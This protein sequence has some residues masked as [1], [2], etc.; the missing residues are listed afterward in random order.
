[1]GK[2]VRVYISIDIE[3]IAGVTSRRHS[4]MDG[5]DYGRARQWMTDTAVAAAEAA[6]SAGASEVVV[7]D[8]HGKK[9]NVHIDQLPAGCRLVRGSPRPLGMMQGIDAGG[10]DAAFLLGYHAGVS[11][12]SG[13]LAH[14]YNGMALREIRVNGRVANE[15]LLNAA[16]AGEHG[17]PVVLVSGDD[18]F[19]EEVSNFLPQARRVVVQQSH[20]VY[21]ATSMTPSAANATIRE[22]ISEALARAG[23]IPP[24]AIAPPVVVELDFKHRLAAEVIAYAPWFDRYAPFSVRFSAP[25]MRTAYSILMFVL[26]YNV[27]LQ[28]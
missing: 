27:G 17:V 13:V 23:E 8:G 14:T 7:A 11:A 10:Y 20:G 26:N 18:V 9:E 19:A 4:A 12:T 28:D 25:T 21:S 16:L 22:A 5:P 6:L 2:D 1:M 24:F 3:G 15:A